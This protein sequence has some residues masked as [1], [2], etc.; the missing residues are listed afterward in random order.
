TLTDNVISGNTAWGVDTILAK[1]LTLRGNRIGTNAA[2]TAALGNGSGGIH[3]SQ[4]PSSTIGIGP[5]GLAI[6][7]GNGG[8]G[9]LIS[10]SPGTKIDNTGVGV[11][12]SATAAV[13]NAG[14]GLHLVGSVGKVTVVN[15]LFSG[16]AGD[17]IHVASSA[18]NKFLGVF[19]GLDSS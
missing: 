3:L 11:D 17:G 14:D 13:P 7:S 19:V 1:K 5:S 18:G 16:N 4:S 12:I 9:I 10:N 2:G 8:D 6:V 15:S